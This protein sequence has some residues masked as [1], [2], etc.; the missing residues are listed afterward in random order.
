MSSKWI[1]L[2]ALVL[3]CVGCGDPAV[4]PAEGIPVQGKVFYRGQPL[5]FGTIVFTPDADRG[6]NGPLATATIQPDGS[7]QLKSGEVIGAVAGWHRV[8]VLA[9]E[10]QPP[11][12]G[13]PQGEPRAILPSR[14]CDPRLSGLL[15][16]VKAG[17]DNVINFN[18]E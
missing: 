11:A 6:T 12:P 13:Q 18:L 4:T 5:P 9:I 2:M 8:T 3:L 14:F 10:M 17:R 16:E 7:F 1:G 15:C